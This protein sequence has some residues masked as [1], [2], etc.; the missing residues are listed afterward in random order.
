MDN[1][2]RSNEIQSRNWWTNPNKNKQQKNNPTMAN[3]LF[4]FRPNITS[5]IRVTKTKVTVTTKLMRYA[6]FKSFVLSLSFFMRS[7][8][9][10][11][12]IAK[13]HVVVFKVTMA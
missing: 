12:S 10:D 4:V 11:I 13:K 9:F 2:L 8:S 7:I 3:S 1:N 6:S 5:G